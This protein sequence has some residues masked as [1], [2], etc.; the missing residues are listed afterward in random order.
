M[1]VT[2]S[3]IV[4]GMLLLQACAFQGAKRFEPGSVVWPPAPLPPR[5]VLSALVHTPQDAGIEKGFWGGMVSA[6]LGLEESSIKRPYGI[7]ADGNGRLFVVDA[8]RRGIHLFDRRGERYAFITGD[9]KNRLVSPIGVAGD[10]SGRIYL[11]DS[12]AGIVYRCDLG[13]LKLE[14]FITTLQRPTGIAYSPLNRLLYVTDTAAAEIVAYN[15]AGREQFRFGGPGSA[16]GRFNHPTDLAID[17]EG[18]VLVT[19]PLNSRIQIFSKEGGYLKSFGEPG[20]T[21][22]HF[23]KPKGVAADSA[24]H[25]YVVDALFDAVQ[26]FDGDG[27]LLMIFGSS[28]NAPGE[29]W[30]PS[31]IFIGADDTIYVADSYNQR[32]QVLAPA[33][34]TAKAGEIKAEGGATR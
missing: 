17:R 30:M 16:P 33:R 10:G 31:G 28:G 3:L 4:L 23:S 34:V 19:D 11:T 26:V 13:T 14:P 8:G 6:I 22:G 24:G 9:R 20:D 21:S 1:G 29:F 7:Y 2:K 25:I 5:L 27:T 18:R 15:E 32:V 12:G